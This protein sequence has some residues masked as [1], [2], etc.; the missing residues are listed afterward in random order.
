MQYILLLVILAADQIV[1]KFVASGMNPGDS[2]PVINNV[3]HITYVQ[4]TGAA[5]SMM[6]GKTVILTVFTA[7]VLVGLFV[8][9][10]KM[11]NKMD[12]TLRSCYALI[13]A[14][15]IGNLID[16]VLRGFVVDM[17]DF[18]IWPV[19]NVADIAICI[20]CTLLV[21]YV[22]IIEPKKKKHG[23]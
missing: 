9:M 2:I 16:R 15:G 6:S 4:N 1:K 22:A 3:F 12:A 13:I 21:A 20:G 14:G 7:I 8:Y 18:R 11:Y 17:F 19:F 5:F 10:V 23:K